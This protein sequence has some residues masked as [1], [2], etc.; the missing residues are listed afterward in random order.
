MELLLQRLYLK[1]EYTIGRL[2]V[3]GLYF[4]DTLEDRVHDLS[5][6]PK[7]PG[8]TAIPAGRYEVTVNRSPRFGRDLPRLLDVPGFTGISTVAIRQPTLRVVSWSEK[9]ANLDGWSTLLPMSCA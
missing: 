1:T 5:C 2:S 7:I 9:T 8:R 6:E 4:C 3:D